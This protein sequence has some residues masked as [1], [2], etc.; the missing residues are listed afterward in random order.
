[1]LGRNVLIRLGNIQEDAPS[2]TA[3]NGDGK[4]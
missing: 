3:D 2:S 1:V 4:K